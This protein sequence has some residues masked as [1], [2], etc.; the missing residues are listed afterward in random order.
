MAILMLW[1]R[2]LAPLRL[3]SKNKAQSLG[4]MAVLLALTVA[5]IVG[6][7]VYIK[8][9]LQARYKAIV[10]ASGDAF[11]YTGTAGKRQYEPYYNSSVFTATANSDINYSQ[12][13]GAITADIT[14][15]T[16][17]R[18]GWQKTGHDFDAENNWN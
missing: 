12:A 9:G 6:M 4:E 16:T 2:L 18:K 8:R 7:Q 14:G 15:D 5:V 10:D 13:A 11:S 3:S 1:N 17:E